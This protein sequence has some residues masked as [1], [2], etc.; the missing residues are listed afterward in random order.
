MW[1]RPYEACVDYPD[2][3]QASQ[4]SKTQRQQFSRLQRGGN[5]VGWWLKPSLTVSAYVKSC[6]SRYTFGDVNSELDTVVAKRASC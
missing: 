3:R 2:F 5:P 6:F 4:L 1:F